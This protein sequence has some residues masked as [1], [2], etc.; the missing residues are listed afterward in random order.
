MDIHNILQTLTFIFTHKID[1]QRVITFVITDIITNHITLDRVFCP[2][3]HN[4]R[5][6]NEDVNLP[7]YNETTMHTLVFYTVT[8]TGSF[9]DARACKVINMIWNNR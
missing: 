3:G 8:Q 6:L 7:S 9:S 2:Q 1:F 4:Q 5:T